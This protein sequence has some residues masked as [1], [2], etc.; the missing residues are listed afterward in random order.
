MKHKSLL[1]HCI[2]LFSLTSLYSSGLPPVL[3]EYIARC[4]NRTGNINFD[5]VGQD[6]LNTHLEEAVN[7]VTSGTTAINGTTVIDIIDKLLDQGANP[8][9]KSEISWQIPPPL[10]QMIRKDAFINAKSGQWVNTLLARD[11]IQN[12]KWLREKK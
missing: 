8:F 7:V 10:I 4:I 6:Q 11:S 9:T 3:Q 2:L 5:G 1:A 12:K